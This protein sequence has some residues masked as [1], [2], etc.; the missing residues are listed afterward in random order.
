MLESDSEYVWRPGRYVM[1][2]PSV[3]W[4]LSFFLGSTQLPPRG[5]ASLALAKKQERER[6]RWTV[7]RKRQRQEETKRKG[8][9][10]SSLFGG[11]LPTHP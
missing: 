5:S 6:E 8:N 11:P 9:T 4:L 1:A 7:M 10:S 2:D 3:G